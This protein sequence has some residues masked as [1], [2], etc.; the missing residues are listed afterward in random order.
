MLTAMNAAQAII[1]D[2]PDKE[3]IW[4]VNTEKEYHETKEK[5]SKT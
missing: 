1:S 2:S 4:N 5:E 3:N